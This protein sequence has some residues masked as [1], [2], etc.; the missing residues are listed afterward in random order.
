[1]PAPFP[2]ASLNNILVAGLGLIQAFYSIHNGISIVL[3][4]SAQGDPISLVG[5]VFLRAVSAFLRGSTKASPQG[6][7]RTSVWRIFTAQEETS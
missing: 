2:P 1:M 6:V 4:L 3:S 5:S 7:L